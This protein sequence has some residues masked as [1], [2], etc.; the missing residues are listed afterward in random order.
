MTHRRRHPL[1]WFALVAMLAVALL[2]TVSHALAHARGGAP[3]WAEI[4]TPQGL[5]SV[6][7]ASAASG[8]DATPVPSA[9][10]LEHCPLC[11]LAADHPGLPPVAAQAGLRLPF[12]EVRLPADASHLRA[13]PARCIAQ[14]R[15]PPADA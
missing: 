8:G 5:R 11:T 10:P 13:L 15:G 14:P 7:L 4:C 9:V 6:V 2:P 3:A 1:I 12:T